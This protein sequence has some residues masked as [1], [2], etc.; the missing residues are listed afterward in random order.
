MI[1]LTLLYQRKFLRLCFWTGIGLL[2]GNFGVGTNFLESARAAAA[3]PRGHVTDLFIGGEGMVTRIL[4]MVQ[5]RD[6]IALGAFIEVAN[7]K[8]MG[9]ILGGGHGGEEQ[10]EYEE[11]RE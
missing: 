7:D 9:A 1:L 11:V 6:H 5:S 10:G 2:G 3:P 4:D 8:E